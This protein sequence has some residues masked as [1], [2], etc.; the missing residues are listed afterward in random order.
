MSHAI[1]ITAVLLLDQALPLTPALDDVRVEEH[2]G[3]RVPTNLTFRDQNGRVVHLADYLQEGRPLLLTL[4]YFNCPMLCGLVLR[5]TASALKEIEGK[6]GKD[7]QALTISFDPQDKPEAALQKQAAVLDQM[8]W[9]NTPDHWPFLTGDAA[10]LER[11]SNS[12][13]FKTVRDEE[14][15]QYA[16]PA[17]LFVLGGDGKISR[18]LYGIEFRPKDVSLALVEA[19][20][21]KVGSTVQQLLL[22]CYA[23]DPATRRYALR[24][25][26]IMRA[27]G[28]GILGAV[29]LLLAG[30]WRRERKRRP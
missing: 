16:H 12:L 21:G 25:A 15:G 24:I 8:G 19:G 17:V 20:Q 30:L 7:Y 28:A 10:T 23:Y 3:A 11:L 1:A 9:E 13:G 22:R 6:P 4:A 2:L 18:Y 29:G 14:T 26:T 27:G 5:G